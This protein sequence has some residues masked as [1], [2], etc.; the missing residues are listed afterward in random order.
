MKNFMP[1][2]VLS[3]IAMACAMSSSQAQSSRF[4]AAPVRLADSGNYDV[5]NSNGTNTTNG[6]TTPS[7]P[8]T[9]ET[10]TENICKLIEEEVEELVNGIMTKV[11]RFREKCEPHTTTSCGGVRG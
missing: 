1:I 7:E 4:P 8:T 6:N 9:C 5:N 3:T 10:K 2:L 11:R